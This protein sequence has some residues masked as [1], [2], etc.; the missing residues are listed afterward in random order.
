MMKR[1]NVLIVIAL[2]L[3][4]IS[5]EVSRISSISKPTIQ[6]LLASKET[7]QMKLDMM[8]KVKL[9]ERNEIN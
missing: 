9:G 8:N 5:L 4:V 3:A 1:R 2:A 6:D 7:N